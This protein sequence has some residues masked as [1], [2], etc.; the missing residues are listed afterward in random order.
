MIFVFVLVTVAKAGLIPTVEIL[1]GPG[2]KTTLT[3]PDGSA[4]A[5]AAPGG[6]VIINGG[7]LGL[8]AAVPAILPSGIKFP[9]YRYVKI[10][11]SCT[12]I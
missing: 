4:L 2:S 11:K 12:N 3:G 9:S 10:S 5:V 8:V 6:A 7:G 1:Q